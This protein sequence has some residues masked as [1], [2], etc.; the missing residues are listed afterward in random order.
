MPSRLRGYYILSGACFLIGLYPSIYFNVAPYFEHNRLGMA[1]SQLVISLLEAI[2]PFVV[3]RGRF[4]IK[5]TLESLIALALLCVFL[6]ASVG[7]GMESITL[8]RSDFSTDRNQKE[9]ASTKWTAQIVTW[10]AEQDALKKKFVP[11]GDEREY[12]PTTGENVR[13][14]QEGRDA[15]NKARDA[16]KYE[17][18]TL[19][20]DAKAAQDKLER[21]AQ[22]YEL[23]KRVD[24]LEKQIAETKKQVDAL[25]VPQPDHIALARNAQKGA[26]IDFLGN[27][28]ATLTYAGEAAAAFGPKFL[29]MLLSLLY[30]EAYGESWKRES[31]SFKQLPQESLPKILPVP[32]STP[33]RKK[34]GLVY[35]PGLKAWVESVR[36]LPGSPGKR[37]APG[38]ALS[39]YQDFCRA[40]DFPYAPHATVLGGLLKNETDLR[41]VVV[42]GGMSLYELCLRPQLAL[43]DCAKETA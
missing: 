31:P 11:I 41:P 22:N 19:I 21:V 2:L 26:Y 30:A 18:K 6:F 33:Q 25:G 17:C 8:A 9:H 15:A 34:R 27:R 24:A 14:A 23:T 28:E 12:L 1:A 39:H 10:N 32:P 35:I 16:C 20:Q 5:G 42:V 37:Y 4:S 3:L 7:N 13:L 38:Q 29:I 36:P 40:R 43:V